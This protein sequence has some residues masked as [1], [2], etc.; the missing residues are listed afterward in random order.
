MSTPQQKVKNYFNSFESRF[1]YAILLKGRKHFGYYPEGQEDL[2]I[3]Q[4]QQLM[5]DKLAEKLHSRVGLRV[6]DAGCGEGK[7]AIYLARKYG[8]RVTGVDLLDWSIK[9]A[10][11]NAIGGGVEQQTK[12]EIMDYT[13]SVALKIE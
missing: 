3:P 2:P 7:V 9:K 10:R 1:G 5:E 11:K 12:F 4:A 8:L 13:T 6:L